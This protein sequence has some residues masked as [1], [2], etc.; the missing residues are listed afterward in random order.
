[1]PAVVPTPLGQNFAG[2]GAEVRLLPANHLSPF[3]LRDKTDAR[4]A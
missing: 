4:D 1:M 2:H 3:V